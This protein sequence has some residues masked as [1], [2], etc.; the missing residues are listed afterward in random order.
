MKWIL[1]G[2]AAS[3]ALIA[4]I[5]MIGALLPRDHVA[6][7]TLTVRRPPEELWTLISDPAFARTATGQDVAVETV[8]STPPRRLV[9][10]IADPNQ[11]FGG[12]WTFTIAPSATGSTLTITENGWVSNVVF[13][14]VSRFVIGHHATMDTYLR[15]VAL[16]LNDEPRLSGQ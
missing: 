5:V 10:K 4:A 1:F 2:V 9:T 14:F 15:Q 7:R 8:E 12:T 13:R 3:A 16:R 6:S 11:P